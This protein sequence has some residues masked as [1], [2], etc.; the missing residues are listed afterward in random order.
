MAKRLMSILLVV[1]VLALGVLALA[2]FDGG[3]Q[4]QRTIVLPITPQ[5]DGQ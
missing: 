5:E 3:R 1:L 2:W 4:E